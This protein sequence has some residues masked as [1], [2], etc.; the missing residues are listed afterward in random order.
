MRGFRDDTPY[1]GEDLFFESNAPEHF[2]VR[3]SRKGVHSHG[4]CLFERRIGNAD[5]TVRFPRDWL[6]DWQT[7]APRHRRADRAAASAA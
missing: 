1:K 7:L 5:V 2:L 6:N 3:C 4:G